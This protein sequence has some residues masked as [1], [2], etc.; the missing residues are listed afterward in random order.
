MYIID[1][2]LRYTKIKKPKIYNIDK[3][4]F[5]SLGGTCTHKN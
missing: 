2:I 4:L 1:K 3:K 5:I